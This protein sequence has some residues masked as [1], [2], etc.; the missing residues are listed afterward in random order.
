MQILYSCLDI[1]T[2]LFALN[3]KCSSPSLFTFF[4]GFYNSY[5]LSWVFFKK[6]YVPI[7]K[8][9]KNCFHNSS[10]NYFSYLKQNLS[11][12]NES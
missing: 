2:E 7:V 8:M 10:M 4:C 6:I 11:K 1:C 9:H 12:V 3:L 5:L